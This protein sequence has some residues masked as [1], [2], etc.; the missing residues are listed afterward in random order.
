MNHK[1]VY[2]M[3][4]FVWSVFLLNAC[5]TDIDIS[6]PTLVPISP[7][8]T[9]PAT[10]S[11]TPSPPVEATATATATAIVTDVSGKKPSPVT[12]PCT[13]AATFI[14]DVTVPDNSQIAPSTGFDKTWRIQNSGTCLWD[15]RYQLVHAGGTL[16]GANASSFPLPIPVAPGQMVDLSISMVTPIA[17][18]SYRS[19]WQLLN[20]E[21]HRFGVG[22]RNSPLW[23]QVI[24]ASPQPVEAGSISGFAWQD[25]DFDNQV[26]E[27]EFLPNVAITLA[28]GANCGTALETMPTDS[29]GRFHFNHLAAGNYCLSGS[30]GSV[31]V[32][33]SGLMLAENQQ[34]VD[35]NVTWPPVW[36]NPATIS[37][38][39]WADGS[40]SSEAD[41][42]I[43]PDEA[44]I[45]GVTVKLMGGSCVGDD[46]PTQHIIETN[47]DGN[48][49]FD[50]LQPGVYCVFIDA[51][52]TS[53]TTILGNGNW[54]FP[55]Y[56]VGYHEITLI[57]GTQANPV[58]FGWETNEGGN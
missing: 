45:A 58:N 57:A 16:L 4:L 38:W 43:Q 56:N 47:G 18:G 2:L 17:D 9:T 48:Y 53:N 24:V 54:T 22:F 33:Q 27:S 5:T 34:L 7:T 21:G 32:S 46:I 51:A 6:E 49:R 28:V 44:Y 30:D 15:G 3:L 11:E 10:A 19:D 14:A 42:M 31:T 29:N 13:D 37:G 23:V 1:K 12:T 20:P 8:Q 40:G 26:E 25:Q 35:V 41:G 52:E 39:V 36:P 50:G 55:S